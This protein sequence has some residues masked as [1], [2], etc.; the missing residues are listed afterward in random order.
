[1]EE[2]RKEGE[3][4]GRTNKEGGGKGG[5]G[6]GVLGDQE[7]KNPGNIHKRGKKVK[8]KSIHFLGEEVKEGGC[9]NSCATSFK[10]G[11][12]GKGR[13]TCGEEEKCLSTSG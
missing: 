7:K 11:G 13:K 2:K 8:G 5:G 9:V 12:G 3:E 6:R 10:K 1:M 4:S